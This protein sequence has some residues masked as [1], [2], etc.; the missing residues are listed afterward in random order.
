MKKLLI[1][2]LL[3]A[4]LAFAAGLSQSGKAGDMDVTVTT[5]KP[6]FVGVNNFKIKVTKG[7]AEVKD[8]AV[9]L[10]VFMPEMPGMPA[11]GEEV[12][13]KAASDGYDAKISFCMKGGWQVTTTVVE[14]GGRT[15]KYRFNVNF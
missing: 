7:G 3:T 14:K 11:M 12:D 8:A 2:L 13:A 1:S 10:K 6:L 4:G 9:K 15:K 5:D